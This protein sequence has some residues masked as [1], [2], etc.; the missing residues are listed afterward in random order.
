MLQRES[1]MLACL[2]FSALPLLTGCSQSGDSVSIAAAAPPP[3]DAINSALQ[4]VTQNWDKNL[5][6][7]SRYT[8]LAA[9][10]NQA[11]RDNNTGLVWEQTP[12]TATMNWA[13]A[14]AHCAKRNTGGTQGWR[15]PSAIEV[16]SLLDYSLPAPF[17][18]ASVFSIQSGYFWS[19]TSQVSDTTTRA[20]QGDF[21][22]N[23]G[24]TVILTNLKTSTIGAWCVRGPMQESVY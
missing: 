17:V 13:T 22:D 7:S 1:L 10:N 16:R 2:A 11:V 5:P 24:Q 23:L 14:Q 19:G 9:F 21:L 6:S 4:G 12:D 20:W 8:V 18:P 3:A 15:L